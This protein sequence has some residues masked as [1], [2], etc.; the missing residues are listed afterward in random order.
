MIS[1]SRLKAQS[2]KRRKIFR[3]SIAL[4]PFTSN[5]VSHRDAENTKKK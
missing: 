3:M 5:D 2:L 4:S 1:G